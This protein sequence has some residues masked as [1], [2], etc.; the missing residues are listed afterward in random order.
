MSHSL[1]QAIVETARAMNARGLN[2]G[3]SGNVSVRLG[4]RMLITPTGMPY[5]QL[6]PGDVVDVAF[7][8]S[9]RSDRLPSS[10][11]PM[12][13]EL[14]LARPEVEAIVHCHP[15]FGTVLACLR[16]EIP[17]FHYMVAIAGGDSIR[18]AP[19][20][21]FGT[22]ELAANVARALEGRKACLLANHGALAVGGSLEEALKIATEVE[23]LAAQYARA[24]QVG[25]PVILGAEEM[26][27]V[28]EKF[29][30]YG[31]ARRRGR[32]A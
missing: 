32:V 25:E 8:G 10:E 5:D 23:N 1:R 29:R 13:S 20:A 24:L 15:P 27:R 17:A 31:Q 19:Y 16:K 30:T 18:C 9:S 7:D 11:W 28:R 26:E 12:H 6:G 21:T 2:S 22:A 4:R 3:T 14:F